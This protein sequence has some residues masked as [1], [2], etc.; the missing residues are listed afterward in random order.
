MRARNINEY[1]CFNAIIRFYYPIRS[2]I[3][4]APPIFFNLVIPLYFSIFI[5]I[6]FSMQ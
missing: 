4:I 5:Y 1:I 6:F 3:F 2:T